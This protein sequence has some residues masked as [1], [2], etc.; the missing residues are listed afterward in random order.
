MLLEVV[1]GDQVVVVVIDPLLLQPVF[2]HLFR[3]TNFLGVVGGEW[4]VIC[5]Y[6]SFN[7]KTT[8]NLTV[9]SK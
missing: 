5:S 6:L 8:V 2:L 7:S 1:D 3:K 9:I 4:L